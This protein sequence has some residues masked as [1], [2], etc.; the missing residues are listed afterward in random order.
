MP[1][2]GHWRRAESQG[3]SHETPGNPVSRSRDCTQPQILSVRTAA[4]S[5][6][7]HIEA[8]KLRFANGKEREYERIAAGSVTPGAVVIVPLLDR[9]NIL[10]VREYAVGLERYELGLPMGLVHGTESTLEAAN[11]EL[12]E[13]TGYGAGELRLLHTMALAPGILGYR[14]DVVLATDLH[15]HRLQGDEPEPLETVL[16]PLNRL[17]ELAA[18]GR[19]SDARTLAALFVARGTVTEASPADGVWAPVPAP[20]ASSKS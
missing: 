4:R 10:L 19:I 17:D 16:W 11:R 5:R 7:F 1:H 8:V 20:G 2:R 6:L 9:R 15:P 14:M 3:R 12:M 13:E 18:D